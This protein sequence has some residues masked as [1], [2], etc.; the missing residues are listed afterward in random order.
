M[1]TPRGF[2]AYTPIILFLI[3][4]SPATAKYSGG[5]GEPN[6]PYQIATAADLIALGEDPNDYDKHFILTADIDLDPNLPAGR[7]F[8]KAVIAPA[9]GDPWGEVRG[10]AFS[11]VIDGSGHSISHLTIEG[12][13]FLGLLGCL[14]S[15]GQVK[16]LR[17]VDVDIVGSGN[18][19][20][21]LVGYSCGSITM[22][23]SSGSVTGSSCV[24]GMIGLNFGGTIA[25]SCSEASV[26]GG[27]DIGGLVGSNSGTYFLDL[28]S[29]IQCCST[30]VVRGNSCVGG[31][32]GSNGLNGDVSN[33]YSTAVVSGIWDLGGLVG[34]NRIQGQVASF[35]WDGGVTR[36]YS[37]GPVAGNGVEWR[38]G[39]LIGTNPYGFEDSL[40]DTETSGQATSAGGTGKITTEMRTAQTFLEVGWDFVDESVNGT[41]DIWWIAEGL[42]YPRL[43]SELDAD[44]PAR[45]AFAPLPIDNSTGVFPS[46]NVRWTH[47]ELTFLHDVYFG[48]DP[49]A[50]ANGTPGDSGVYCGRFPAE[51]AT[52]DPG[53]LGLE[54]TYY[55]RIDEINEADSNSRRK[56]SVWSFTTIDFIVVSIVDDFESY[57]PLLLDTWISGFGWDEPEPNHPGNG[58]GSFVLI[59]DTSI[60]YAGKQSMPMD[61]NNV[62]EPWYSETER[63]WETPQDWTVDGADT[64]TLYFRGEPDNGRDPL[65]VGIEDSVGRMATV[66]HPD[67][68]ALL[69]TEW[70]KWHI[71]FADLKAAGVDV[72]AVKKMVIGVGDRENP[73]PGGTGRIYIDDIRLTKRMP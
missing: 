2:R 36:C 35:S 4:L 45:K 33:C 22:S 18:F 29:V 28:G 40:W 31:L 71:P 50:V 54:K 60:V 38:V 1:T 72:A 66:V 52:Y 8:D 19:V 17:L 12:A 56:G 16:D 65:Y 49:Q 41:Q 59:A 57:I 47:G 5:T 9:T 13:T 15:D 3:F 63:T 23:Y 51:V 73:Q 11:G 26:S 48:D 7:I 25:G 32:V 64:L 62:N 21:G 55:W 24:G 68:E 42:A 10:R 30:G 53:V 34:L 69:A 70:Q 27:G 14:K 46:I 67:A 44:L 43:H 20:G 61:Y 6:D 37:T 39:G 58:S